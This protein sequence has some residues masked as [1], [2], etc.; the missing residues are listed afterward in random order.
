VVTFASPCAVGEVV[1][2]D[3]EATADF[4]DVWDLGVIFSVSFGCHGVRGCG[5]Y[6][7]RVVE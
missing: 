3:F 6:H 5:I 1:W 7:S 2:A 4:L